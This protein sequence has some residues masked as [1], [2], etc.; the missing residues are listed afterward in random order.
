MEHAQRSRQL[1]RPYPIMQELCL[2]KP[3][4]CLFSW[5]GLKEFTSKYS[6]VH[7]VELSSAGIAKQKQRE[8]QMADS[9]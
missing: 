8:S 1:C 5:T 7:M 6:S 9:C 4:S 2:Q 3:F